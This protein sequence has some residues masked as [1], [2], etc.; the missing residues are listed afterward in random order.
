MKQRNGSELFGWDDPRSSTIGIIESAPEDDQRSILTA[1]FTQEKLQRRHILVVLSEQSHAF[2]RLAE[3]EAFVETVK[4]HSTNIV[5]VLSSKSRFMRI[6]RDHQFPVFTSLEEYL[7]SAQDLSTLT[8]K[9]PVPSVE[10]STLSPSEEVQ[11]SASDSAKQEAEQK[12]AF[13]DASESVSGVNKT[14]PELSTPR[15]SREKEKIGIGTT[16][17]RQSPPQ[18]SQDIKPILLNPQATPPSS[19]VASVPVKTQNSEDT[20]VSS[21]IKKPLSPRTPLLHI[22]PKRRSF[23]S[24]TSVIVLLLLIV[25]SILS[26][27]TGVGPLA[28][29]LPFTAIITITP[30]DQILTQRYQFVAVTQPSDPTKQ[31]I[32]ARFLS[33]APLSRTQI[34]SSSGRGIIPARSA[35]GILTFYNALT[36]AQTIPA[37]TVLN[38]ENG[39]Q[40]SNDQTVTIPAATPPTEG[41]S[42]VTMHALTPGERGNI[43]A[44]DFAAFACCHAGIT[45]TNTQPF[46]GG[47]DQKSYSYL[48]QADIDMAA[49]EL[50]T[51][52]SPLGEK[53]VQAQI[54]PEEQMLNTIR[55]VPNVVS[56]HVAGEHVPSAT[57]AETVQCLTEV[58]SRQNVQSLATN[59]LL[60]ASQ[61]SLG[62]NYVL[63]GHIA[64]KLL[65]IAH[66]DNKG[67]AALQ[68]MAQ[69][70][71][72]YQVDDAQKRDLAKLVAGKNRDA[73]KAL[74]Q[75]Q[76]GIHDVGIML[77]RLASNTLPT[78]PHS[79]TVQIQLPPDPSAY[80]NDSQ[81][82]V[83]LWKHL[84]YPACICS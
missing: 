21:R 83:V 17:A 28:Q 69:G 78:D 36:Q 23:L 58:Y 11:S 51:N 50:Q 67:A 8:S 44:L 63:T 79:I 66:P 82:P 12:N 62:A 40:L 71:W 59:L 6:A 37:G 43:A 76:P 18:S 7:R 77:S 33:S 49:Q 70:T 54:F 45:I 41:T 19:S 10:T 39:I 25:G 22:A 34:V 16:P 61:K 57:V 9:E 4:A 24:A 52:L 31:Q 81:S 75:Q 35:Q 20:Q 84:W 30:A 47:V 29:V 68:M 1:I 73:A 74:L 56:N 26:M 5:F 53:A 15:S 64:T 3:F 14:S 27:L 13:P 48:Q 65:A 60:T 42:A 32:Q 46:S 80:S 2:H 72:R 55:C 38:N